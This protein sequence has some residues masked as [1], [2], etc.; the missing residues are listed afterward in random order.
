M[1]P[2]RMLIVDDSATSRLMIKTYVLRVRP[3]WRLIEAD[4]GVAAMDA[5][6]REPVDLVSID[7]NMPGMDGLTLARRIRAQVPELRMVIFTANIQ[8][9]MR[10]ESA[11]IGAA[12]VNKPVTERSVAEMLRHFDA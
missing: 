6:F 10:A 5:I 4:G 3:D 8:D 11:A 9:H 2:R 1:L 12:L 7:Y